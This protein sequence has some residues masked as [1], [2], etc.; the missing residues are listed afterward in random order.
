LA[1]L[2]STIAQLTRRNIA[3][4]DADGKVAA[5]SCRAVSSS[6]IGQR[7][8]RPWSTEAALRNGSSFA[9]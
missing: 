2:M 5:S 8:R 9:M 3:G 1:T 6:E 4:A 7:G